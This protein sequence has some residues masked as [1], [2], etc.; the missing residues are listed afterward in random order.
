MNMFVMSSIGAISCILWFSRSLICLKS[1]IT[2]FKPLFTKPQKFYDVTHRNP[3]CVEQGERFEWW[4][5][6]VN[7]YGFSFSMVLPFLLEA[8]R[9]RKNQEFLQIAVGYVT[10]RRGV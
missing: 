4:M 1:S 8:T 9:M 3:P 7:T 10:C 2:A 5:W 6:K